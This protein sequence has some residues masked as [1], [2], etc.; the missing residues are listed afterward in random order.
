M[1]SCPSP[2]VGASKTPVGLAGPSV[3]AI[4]ADSPPLRAVPLTPRCGGTAGRLPAAP[5]TSGRLAVRLTS[6]GSMLGMRWAGTVTEAVRPDLWPDWLGA[7]LSRTPMP[8]R[9]ARRPTTNRPMRRD[10]DTSTDDGPPAAGWRRPARA[11]A[12]PTPR[13][14]ISTTI[15]PSV[16][17]AVLMTTCESGGEKLVALSSSSASRWTTSDAARPATVAVGGVCTTTRWY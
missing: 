16:A 5:A 3:P 8:W 11:S 4:S 7:E 13:S 10:A 1:N 2:P 6:T 9:A 12:M 15:D 14:A 17:R